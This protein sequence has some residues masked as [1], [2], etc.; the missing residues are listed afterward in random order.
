MVPSSLDSFEQSRYWKSGC[1]LNSLLGHLYCKVSK[2]VSSREK[3]KHKYKYNKHFFKMFVTLESL[4]V[5][6]V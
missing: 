3:N 2:T 5:C 6:A 4:P 1:C